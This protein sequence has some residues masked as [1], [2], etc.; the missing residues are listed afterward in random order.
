MTFMRSMKRAVSVFAILAMMLVTVFSGAVFAEENT[1]VQLTTPQNVKA[2]YESFY[3]C[4]ISWD[5]VDGANAYSLSITKP[6]G[7]TDTSW[8]WARG[9][10]S[11]EKSGGGTSFMM[12]TPGVYKFKVA[13]VIDKYDGNPTY[14][15][16]SKIVKVTMMKQSVKWK[17]PSK[18]GRVY[19]V[20]WKKDKSA[21]GYIL[22]YSF[23]KSTDKKV[24]SKIYTK[25]ISSKK[26]SFKL[27]KMPKKYDTVWISMR[28]YK[29]ANGKK[30]YWE[31]PVQYE[32][33]KGKI[34]KSN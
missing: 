10:T 11:Y 8:I 14:G 9:T 7:E 6:N 15:P 32:I 5:P 25:Y 30:L 19:T 23:I 22:T 12:D 33:Y 4:F 21:S 26:T 28:P 20:K 16:Y 2:K 31:V 34:H 29:K 3:S 27:K 13:A 17:K 24:E 18:K 1:D